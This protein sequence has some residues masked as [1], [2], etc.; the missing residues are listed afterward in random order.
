VAELVA[1]LASDPASNTT[2]SYFLTD[3]GYKAQ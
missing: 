1:F 2:G 3:G